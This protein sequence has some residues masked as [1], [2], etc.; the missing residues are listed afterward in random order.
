MFLSIWNHHKCLILALSASFEYLWYTAIIMLYF[1]QRGMDFRRRIL[2]SMKGL[3]YPGFLLHC[4]NL[5]SMSF[6]WVFHDKIDSFHDKIQA[7]TGH[8]IVEECI[9]SHG[10]DKKFQ[11]FFIDKYFFHEFSMSFFQIP[12]VF[13]AWIFLQLS[14]FSITRRNPVINLLTFVW[15]KYILP[16]EKALLVGYCCLWGR[17]IFF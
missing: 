3:I 13:Q 14:R 9:T 1:F 15:N 12:W 2:T 4:V 6:P 7:Y 8:K 16:L 10:L 17:N 5:N 11:Y